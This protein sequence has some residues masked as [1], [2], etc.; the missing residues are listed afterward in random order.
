M[1]K[2]T[3]LAAALSIMN[4]MHQTHATEIAKEATQGYGIQALRA[5][6]SGAYLTKDALQYAGEGTLNWVVN[7][8]INATTTTIK[9]SW[10]DPKVAA[11][12]LVALGTT[13]LLAKHFGVDTAVG[14]AARWTKDWIAPNEKISDLLTTN[15][16][17]GINYTIT[18]KISELVL[19][20]SSQ[21]NSVDD[22]NTGKGGQALLQFNPFMA[23]EQLKSG[24]I[25][26][27]SL[28]QFILADTDLNPKTITISGTV[29]IP[30]NITRI[31]ASKTITITQLNNDPDWSKTAQFVYQTYV[32]EMFA[33]GL[34][35]KVSDI[36]EKPAGTGTYTC[37]ITPS[38]IAEKLFNKQN[39]ATGALAGLTNPLLKKLPNM[40]TNSITL[41]NYSSDAMKPEFIT[42]AKKYM[43]Y[44]EQGNPTGLTLPWELKPEY[45]IQPLDTYTAQ[46]PYL[47]GLLSA[48]KSKIT[49]TLKNEKMM[50]GSHQL[51]YV[52]TMIANNYDALRKEIEKS[53][54]LI[55][56]RNDIK[57]TYNAMIQQLSIIFDL[58]TKLA[59][60]IRADRNYQQQDNIER[61]IRNYTRDLTRNSFIDMQQTRTHQEGNII[62]GY[63]HIQGI[64]Q[65]INQ[66]NPNPL[67][68][69]IL[70]ELNQLINLD[71][72]N[73]LLELAESITET[74]GQ[75]L[76]NIAVFQTL[77]ITSALSNSLRTIGISA[78]SINQK[79][80]EYLP[81]QGQNQGAQPLNLTTLK[82]TIEYLS[83]LIN[84]TSPFNITPSILELAGFMPTTLHN[85]MKIPD[86]LRILIDRCNGHT[87]TD[88]SALN[89]DYLSVV[90][91]LYIA[92]I[93]T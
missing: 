79:L 61:Y 56:Y 5:I 18:A 76:H 45:F 39:F 10:N 7:P 49:Y 35:T 40:L 81:A 34:Y 70:N 55:Q 9:E 12:A 25:P 21:N 58:P 22:D 92:P 52:K 37:T 13:G 46:Q 50:F 44:N 66:A 3:I 64:I 90:F 47:F 28:I 73:N 91:D 87:S 14:N 19:R 53:N 80:R 82:K 68:A 15:I 30:G 2:I 42:W 24:F 77:T 11:G 59:S 41:T 33:K 60:L 16:G 74:R 36:P 8:L 20:Y 48:G 26:E 51:A 88:L 71:P 86:S 54:Q 17:R 63:N 57:N 27:K 67:A 84:E 23:N 1:K 32:Q 38:S 72:F 83:T 65:R 31:L 4:L 29:T 78:Q 75:L 62:A 89:E 93:F 69:T 85:F 6:G 43:S